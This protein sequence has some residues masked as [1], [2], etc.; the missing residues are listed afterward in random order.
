[1]L[2]L[3]ASSFTNKMREEIYDSPLHLEKLPHLDE[4]VEFSRVV[5]CADDL[6]CRQPTSETYTDHK[7]KTLPAL[8]KKEKRIFD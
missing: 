7:I 6:L 5:S 2:G 8:H 1:M 4:E 3:K